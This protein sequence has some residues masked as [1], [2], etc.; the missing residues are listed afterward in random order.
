MKNKRFFGMI[1]CM[2]LA[3]GLVL[4]GCPTEDSGSSGGGGGNANGMGSITI[5][6]MKAGLN[7]ANIVHSTVSGTHK[8]FANFSIEG[9]TMSGATFDK[10]GSDTIS[11]GSVTIPVRGKNAS[12]GSFEF[13]DGTYTVLLTVS[14]AT[15][16]PADNKQYTVDVTFSGAKGTGTA[17]ATNGLAAPAP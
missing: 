6:G 11:G 5:T 9:G 7:T 15:A 12:Q 14:G 2:A 17:T 4:T 16:N 13:K 8:D 3:I 1:V 10:T